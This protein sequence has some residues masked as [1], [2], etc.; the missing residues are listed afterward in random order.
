ML[1]L[2]LKEIAEGEFEGRHE[3]L[4]IYQEGFAAGARMEWY[5][6]TIVEVELTPDGEDYLMKLIEQGRTLLAGRL[7]DGKFIGLFSHAIMTFAPAFKECIPF[8]SM[9]I[10]ENV[11]N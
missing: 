1:G 7:I 6:V 4:H 5:S 8:K 2:N 9:R 11:G 10:Y 3:D